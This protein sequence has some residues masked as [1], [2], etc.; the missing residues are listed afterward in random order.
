MRARGCEPGSR[1]TDRAAFLCAC[2]SRSSTL[3]PFFS[4]WTPARARRNA[5]P[6]HACFLLSRFPAYGSRGCERCSWVC[7]G[8]P[9]FFPVFGIFDKITDLQP[10]ALRRLTPFR[11]VLQTP[12][13]RLHA[14]R[15]FTLPI[16]LFSRR[17]LFCSLVTEPYSASGPWCCG[18]NF[19]WINFLGSPWQLY[20]GRTISVD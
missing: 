15:R 18:K 19:S 5:S 12:F 1:S 3:P 2:A 13:S 8:S 20:L 4:A 7:L 17:I 16:N 10:S 6:A 11:V 14:T 9:P